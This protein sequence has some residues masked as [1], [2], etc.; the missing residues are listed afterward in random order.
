MSTTAFDEV[1]KIW[2]GPELDF[3]FDKYKNFGEFLLEN[4]AD[5][6]SERVMQ[7]NIVFSLSMNKKKLILFF[8]LL[9][10]QINGDTGE[11]LTKAEVRRRTIQCAKNLIKFGCNSDQR[12]AVIARNHHN[13]IPL[14]FSCF[15]IGTPITA[16]D[17]GILLG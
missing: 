16:L 1:T 10:I 9:Q 13:L 5:T 4:L 7:V 6:D 17:I 2:S 12:I 3:Q 15:C 14:M 8:L 11:S